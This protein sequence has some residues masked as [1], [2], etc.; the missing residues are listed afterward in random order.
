MFPRAFTTMS[1]VVDGAFL[2]GHPQELL[3]SADFQPVTSIIG[4]NND[5]FGWFLPTVRS[6]PHTLMLGNPWEDGEHLE[7]WV[8]YPST[9][10]AHPCFPGYEHV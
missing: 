2:S 9:Q 10:D 5:E 7:Q 3:A 6:P 8:I 1:G 4:V